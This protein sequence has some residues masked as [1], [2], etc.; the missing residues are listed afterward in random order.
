M[1]GKNVVYLVAL[2]VTCLFVVLVLA[3][4]PNLKDVFQNADQSSKLI[5][6][7]ENNIDSDNT[8]NNN[9]EK[10]IIKSLSMPELSSELTSASHVYVSKK[11]VPIIEQPVVRAVKPV[12]TPIDLSSINEQLDQPKDF[13][14][15]PAVVE[16]SLKGLVAPRNESINESYVDPSRPFMEF[17]VSNTPVI[18]QGS[19]DINEFNYRVTYNFGWH[20]TDMNLI[21]NTTDFQD[22]LAERGYAEIN[23]RY[24]ED[25]NLQTRITMLSHQKNDPHA[26]QHI[27]ETYPVYPSLEQR[28]SFFMWDVKFNKKLRMPKKLIIWNEHSTETYPCYLIEHSFPH[29][30]TSYN[31]DYTC[32]KLP[33]FND[34]GGSLKFIFN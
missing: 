26:R 3:Y 32:K 28:V 1:E 30:G 18:N 33:N 9:Q 14:D 7:I 2:I 21:N 23:Y 16:R 6:H 15:D 24:T 25:K 22:S 12:S 10:P 5:N 29:G 20:T 34:Y 11:P 19:S 8:N 4:I 17:N 27:I 13:I 31:V